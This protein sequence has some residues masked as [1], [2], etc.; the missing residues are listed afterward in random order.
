ML[1]FFIRKNKTGEPPCQQNNKK[2]C[3]REHNEDR[4]RFH[5][6]HPKEPAS[7]HDIITVHGDVLVILKTMKLAKHTQN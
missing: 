6:S 1:I 7:A 4:K 2:D 5:P 3:S